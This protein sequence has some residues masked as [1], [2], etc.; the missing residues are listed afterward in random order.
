MVRRHYE[1]VAKAVEQL[2]VD[3]LPALFAAPAKRPLP[4]DRSAPTAV[5]LVNGF[6]GLGLATLTKVTQLFE[7]QFRNVVFVSVGE[8]N[9]GLFKGINEIVQLEENLAEDLS[10]YC[11]LAA[12]MGFNAELRVGIGADVVRELRWLCLEVAHEFPR[13]VFFAGQLVFSEEMDGFFTRFLHN[14][15][16][17]SWAINLD[18]NRDKIFTCKRSVIE[19]T[20]LW[21]GIE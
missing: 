10:D 1:L 5:L 6:N 13:A 4:K 8:V 7:G 12:D 21:G 19:R 17:P 11:K 18:R 14:H 3:I 20:S 16:A 2:E 9:S 15:T